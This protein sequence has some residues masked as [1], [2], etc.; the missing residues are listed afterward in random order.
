MDDS[1]AYVASLSL[2]ECFEKTEGLISLEAAALLYNLA[3]DVTD[4]CI[5]EVGSYRG[6]SAVALGR[7]S[8]DGHRVPVFAIEPH[9][10]FTGV[11]GGKFGPVDRGAFY[12]AM[13]DTSC[14][15]VVRLINLGSTMVAPNWNR[16]V[17][18]LWI[19]GDHTYEGVKTD[20]ES[21]LPHLNANA[22]VVFDDVKNPKLGPSQLIKEL[23][24]GG[25]FEERQRVGKVAVL[26]RKQ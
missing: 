14:Y 3:K 12:Q 4:G 18:L 10:E 8:L 7:G 9:E 5:V 20:F 21:W 22:T 11:L 2:Q 24:D 15:H 19:D 17:S 26:V 16:N 13:L 23:I 25:D 6:R 1:F